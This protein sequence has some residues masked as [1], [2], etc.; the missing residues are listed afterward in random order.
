MTYTT[1]RHLADSWGL[2]AMGIIYLLL[3]A[4]AFRPGS[5]HRNHAAAMAIFEDREHG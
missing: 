2:V 5:R 3:C 4:W 1:L